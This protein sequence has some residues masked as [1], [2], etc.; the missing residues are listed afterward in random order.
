MGRD[1][2]T[3][4]GYNYFAPFIKIVKSDL[5]I[6][7]KVS[8][9]FKALDANNGGTAQRIE[10]IDEHCEYKVC[11]NT[12]HKIH[13][14]LKTIAHELR[15]V[16]QYERGMLVQNDTT[17]TWNKIVYTNQH[18]RELFSTNP[19]GYTNLPWELDAETYATNSVAAFLQKY[20]K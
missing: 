10:Y 15:H 1:N 7:S 11:V 2:A 9:S 6:K 17:R 8:F 20:S 12:N 5:G 13:N 4:K 16:Y 14:M 3:G 19:S 18:V